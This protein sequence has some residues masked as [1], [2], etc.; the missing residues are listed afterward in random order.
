MNKKISYRIYLI[1]LGLFSLSPSL[2]GAAPV[3]TVVPATNVTPTS[4]VAMLETVIN[5]VL[6]VAGALAALML[7]YGGIKYILSSG[8][9][10]RTESAKKT[11]LYAIIGIIVITAAYFLVSL[12]ANILGSTQ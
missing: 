2:V 9:E 12:G 11:I 7:I 10:K 8:D 1:F 4:V 3:I 5:W 6:A